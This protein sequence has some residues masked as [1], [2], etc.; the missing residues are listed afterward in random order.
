MKAIATP[1]KGKRSIRGWLLFGW[2]LFG[3]ITA[4]WFAAASARADI[5]A[6]EDSEGVIHYSNQEVPPEAA[7]YM[8]EVSPPA[9]AEPAETNDENNNSKTTM[10]TD[11]QQALAQEHLEEVNRKL[12][13]ALEK[14][15]DLTASVA[16]SKAQA[17]AATEAAREAER[18]AA[19][20]RDGR[21]DVQERVIVHAVPYRRYGHHRYRY[22]NHGNHYQKQKVT[23]RR[24][25]SLNHEKR[26]RPHIYRAHSRIEKING[27]R[28]IPNE[29]KIPGPILPPEPYRIPKAYGIR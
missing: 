17:E 22:N 29:Y 23:R 8:R 7:L 3:W 16:R 18:E 20:A 28:H 13:R 26:F 6:W 25:R 10:E 15:D 27:R 9:N 14:V 4:G 5:Y 1:P 24:S 2:L 11:R 12:S 19:A 21:S